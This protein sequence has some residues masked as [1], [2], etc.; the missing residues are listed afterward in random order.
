MSQTSTSIR[1]PVSTVEKRDYSVQLASWI[2]RSRAGRKRLDGADCGNI[3]REAIRRINVMPPQ[4]KR[5][6]RLSR[7]RQNGLHG[8]V[9][10]RTKP[11]PSR[12]CRG[13]KGGLLCGE[14]VAPLRG[15]LRADWTNVSHPTRQERN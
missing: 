12:P 3:D 6:H 11:T 4:M 9:K 2:A 5:A 7:R 15:S 10:G 1:L 13:A 8:R 14:G